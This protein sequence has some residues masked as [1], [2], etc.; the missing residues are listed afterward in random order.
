MIPNIKPTNLVFKPKPDTNNM[1]SSTNLFW[2]KCQNLVDLAV[3]Y[4]TPLGNNRNQ[5][6]LS[7]LAGQD[8]RQ[9]RTVT[10]LTLLDQ[11]KVD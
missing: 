9:T 7:H 6:H 5:F 1:C 4:T 11:T 3:E 2:V 8:T 10:K